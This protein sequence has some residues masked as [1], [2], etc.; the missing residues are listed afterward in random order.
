MVNRG[1]CRWKRVDGRLGSLAC[2]LSLAGSLASVAG[3]AQ[4]LVF[5]T[6]AAK[7]PLPQPVG[8]TELNLGATWGYDAN[9][10]SYIDPSGAILDTPIIYG[11]YY[12][13]PAFPQFVN[14]DPFTLQGLFKWRGEHIDPI[15]DATTS[16]GHFF[17]GCGFKAELVLRG[18]SCD[19]VLGWYNFTGTSAPPASTDIHPLVPKSSSYLNGTRTEFV[20]LGWDNRNPRVLSTLDWTPQAFSSGDITTNPEYAGGDV[21]FALLGVPSTSCKADKFSVY[22]HNTKNANGVPWVTSLIYRSTADPTAI[23]MAFEDLPM[24][25][26]DWH[27]AGGQ[28]KNDGDFNDSVFFISGL[29]ATAECPDP[30]CANKVC[31]QGETC[32]SGVCVPAGSVPGGGSASG[33]GAAGDG[34]DG[35]GGGPDSGNDLG[36]AGPGPGNGTAGDAAIPNNTA[37]AADKPDDGGAGAPDATAAGAPNAAGAGDGAPATS[38]A[39]CSCRVGAEHPRTLSS[40]LYLALAAASALRRRRARPSCSNSWP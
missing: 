36:G 19:A 27:D 1:R 28:Y 18:G 34:G 4:A 21:A 26:A 24:L 8:T 16:P 31:L 14:G 40:W 33:G 25:P 11:A 9:T 37:G 30:A 7:T 35:A 6:D 2:A 38:S 23:Y 5:Q 29:G 32:S 20:P 13:P 17:P 3:P 15:A 22:E 10:M 39:G 12:S